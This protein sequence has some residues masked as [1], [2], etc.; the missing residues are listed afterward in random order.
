MASTQQYTEEE[1]REMMAEIREMIEE[2]GLK[3]RKRRTKRRLPRQPKQQ[4]YNPPSLSTRE[5]PVG[6]Q[7]LKSQSIEVE[8]GTVKTVSEV[9]LD[10]LLDY[11]GLNYVNSEDLSEEEIEA[12]LLDYEELLQQT[13]KLKKQKKRLPRPEPRPPVRPKPPVVEPPVIEPPVEPRPPERPIFRP[14]MHYDGNYKA[15]G[16][17]DE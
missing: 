4:E 12:L 10:G 17:D 16:D 15:G 3:R 2:R 1:L 6:L 11:F 7:Q 8:D 5:H 14:H 9:D 13:R